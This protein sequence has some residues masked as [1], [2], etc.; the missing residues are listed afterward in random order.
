[1]NLLQ[2]F[3]ATRAAKGGKPVANSDAPVTRDEFNTVLR[4]VNALIEEV[5]LITSPDKLKAVMN[6]ALTEAAKSAP[7]TVDARARADRASL[8]PT[9]EPT[10]LAST[11]ANHRNRAHLAPKGE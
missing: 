11:V 5:D 7:P 6:E 1:M 9:D 3:L 2:Q 4:A 10:E 8:A